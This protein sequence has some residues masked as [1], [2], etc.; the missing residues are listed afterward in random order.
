M[1]LHQMQQTTQRR[2]YEREKACGVWCSL[3]MWTRDARDWRHVRVTRALA[4]VS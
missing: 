3:G 1:F 4:V 2:C